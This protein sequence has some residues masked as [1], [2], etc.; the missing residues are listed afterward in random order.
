[1][2]TTT[3]RGACA[4]ALVL[5]VAALAGCDKEVKLTFFN[6]TDQQRDVFLAGPGDPSG[7]GILGTV[8][9][10]SKLRTKIKVDKGFLPANYNWEAGDKSGSFTITKDSPGELMIAIEPGG[11]VGP[12]DK[13]TEIKKS[14][15]IEAEDVIIDQDTV[16]E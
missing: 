6:G 14:K 3:T 15:K 13:N 16:V 10:I 12:I 2:S 9:P 1:M 4:G 7:T 5:A 11:V 8:G